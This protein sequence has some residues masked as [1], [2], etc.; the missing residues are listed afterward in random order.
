MNT[1]LLRTVDG[2]TATLYFDTNTPHPQTAEMR[3]QGTKGHFS[4]NLRQVYFEDRSP[5]PHHWEDLENYREEFDHPVW[6]DLDP[7]SFKRARG[8]G[9]GVTSSA[10]VATVGEGVTT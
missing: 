10:D 2:K 5:Q 6:R 7:E 4:G 3:L 1:T 8:H 9:G